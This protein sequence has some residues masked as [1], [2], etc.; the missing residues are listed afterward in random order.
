LRTVLSRGVI[1]TG[2]RL[3]RGDLVVE[4]GHIVAIGEDVEQ[5][6][7][8]RV[9]D[10]EGKVV[11]PSFVDLH[12][13]LRFPGVDEADDPESV[14]RAG[15]AGGFGVLVAM[16]NT[17][18]PIDRLS[19]WHEANDRFRGLGV[20]VIQ[21]TSVTMDREG[22][23]LVDV[24]ALADAGVLIMSDDGSGIQRSDVMRDALVASA[25]YG[26]VI[27]QHSEDARLAAGG[28]INDGAFV[29]VLGVGGIPEVAESAMVARDVELLKVIPG[30]LHL[31]HVT[32]R[33]S[34]NLYR[35]AK[36]EG[37]RISAEVTPHHLLLPEGRVTTGDTRF[38][39]N[40]PLRSPAT[41]MA[42]VQGVVDGTFDC[43]AT[44]HAPHP[45]SRKAGSY[46]DAAFGMLG[47]AEAWSAAWMA[48][49][50]SLPADQ[51]ALG[52]DLGSRTWLAL[53]RVLGALSVGPA[54]VL[55]RS[56]GLRAGAVADVVVLDPEQ[57]PREV[58]SRWYR[59]KNTPYQGEE[60]I[61]RVDEVFLRGSQ[62]VAD[63][64]V[65]D[66]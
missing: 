1:F 44:D 29:E 39:V 18:P 8:D 62:L 38:K 21:A 15:L 53:A 43:I 33:E 22:T 14:A 32:A 37:L 64:E 10:C 19:R 40:P 55:G 36:R 31:Q 52:P 45:D 17:V 24:E 28:V 50:R 49:R 47:L 27:A 30:Q 58:P 35:Q 59:S 51:A 46:V 16:A 13:H 63:G 23:Q 12:T 25:E 11:A 34:L 6:R 2:T 42:L 61:G 48:V 5:Y 3:L 20:E 60:L 66:V 4:D 56:V 9:I 57:R 41:Q 7:G 65:L 54:A 26:V